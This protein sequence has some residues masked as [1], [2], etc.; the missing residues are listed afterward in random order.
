VIGC[1]GLCENTDFG[2]LRYNLAVKQFPALTQT[3]GLLARQKPEEQGSSAIA[4]ATFNSF[5]GYFLVS[6]VVQ[7]A[8]IPTRD[9]VKPNVKTQ[10]EKRFFTFNH[11]GWVFM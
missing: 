9:D 2:H 10:K 4:S 8:N 5:L 6:F 1:H 7:E 11:P 3:I